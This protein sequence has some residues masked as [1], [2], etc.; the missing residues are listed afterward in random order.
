MQV[1][2]FPFLQIT[3]FPIPVLIESSSTITSRLVKGNVTHVQRLF[4]DI[5]GCFE[6][7]TSGVKMNSVGVF[8]KE[9]LAEGTRNALKF[10]Q[11]CIKIYCCRT[12]RISSGTISGT[13]G[14]FRRSQ[15][16]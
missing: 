3:P 12:Y 2:A 8:C 9:K 10:M 15:E 5:P 11:S 6:F 7:N 1:C 16:V 13:K 14:Q 4:P